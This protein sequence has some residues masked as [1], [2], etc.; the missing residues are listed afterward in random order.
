MM[1]SETASCGPS[2][3]ANRASLLSAQF[4]TI[5]GVPSWM[6]LCFHGGS[7]RSGRSN[8]FFRLIVRVR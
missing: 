7:V 1:G 4:L 5:G 6:Q 3:P 2:G 8:R